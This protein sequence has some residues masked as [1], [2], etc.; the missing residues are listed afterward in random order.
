M[1][2]LFSGPGVFYPMQREV[3]LFLV[4]YKPT[5]SMM[6]CLPPRSQIIFEDIICYSEIVYYFISGIG[7]ELIVY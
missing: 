6:I 4:F 1:A 3:R 7:I 5:I 2:G